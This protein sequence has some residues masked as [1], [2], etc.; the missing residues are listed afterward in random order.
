[1][2]TEY[3][4]LFVTSKSTNTE[5]RIVLFGPNYSNNRIIRGNN[6]RWRT[7][8]R[9]EWL[10]RNSFHN[11]EHPWSCEHEAT[12]G[13]CFSHPGPDHRLAVREATALHSH[14]HPGE[15]GGW[16]WPLVTLCWPLGDLMWPCT[17]L[18]LPQDRLHIENEDQRTRRLARETRERLHTVS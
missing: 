8:L 18:C 15:G 3:R 6:G 9:S 17:D 13:P 7:S 14:H 12:P 11:N 4:I 1:M 5:Y 2:N 10:M 16:H